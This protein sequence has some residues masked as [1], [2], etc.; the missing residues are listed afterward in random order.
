MGRI[1][2]LVAL[3]LGVLRDACAEEKGQ[4]PEDIIKDMDKDG[5]GLVTLEELHVGVEA[6]YAEGGHNGWFEENFAPVLKEKFPEADT[7]G[8]G[9]LHAEEVKALMEMFEKHAAQAGK[10]E[11]M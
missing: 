9:K 6:F 11:E 8:D 7:D 3:L 10:Q 1:C 5:D 4:T 2:L